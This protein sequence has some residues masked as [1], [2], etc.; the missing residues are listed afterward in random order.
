MR[1]LGFEC[2]DSKISVF[3][4]LEAMSVFQICIRMSTTWI[5]EMV[6]RVAT[7]AFAIFISS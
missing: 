1:L 6:R 7:S 5:T 2:R 3:Y 4:I